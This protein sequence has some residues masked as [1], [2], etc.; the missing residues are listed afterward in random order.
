[1][2]KFNTR[3]CIDAKQGKSGVE[4]HFSCIDTNDPASSEISDMIIY[5]IKL[6]ENHQLK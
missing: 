3:Y 2:Q 6:I 4:L 5:Y 1:L